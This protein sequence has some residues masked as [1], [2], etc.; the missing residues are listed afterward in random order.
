MAHTT[1]TIP[2]IT[3][4]LVLIT[5][6]DYANNCSHIYMCRF[7]EEVTTKHQWVGRG[8]DGFPSLEGNTEEIVG[9]E[10]IIR[11]LIFKS[12]YRSENPSTAGL[13]SRQGCHS[14]EE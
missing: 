6:V 3:T 4:K 9:N 12:I 5:Q 8:A 2:C 10:L 14:A 1:S 11:Y 13:G 7:D